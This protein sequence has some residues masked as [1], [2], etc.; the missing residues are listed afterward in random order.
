MQ[1]MM[2]RP[3]YYNLIK[4]YCTTP[5]HRYNATICMCVLLGVFALSI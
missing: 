1:A 5:I 2:D 3:I 4:I